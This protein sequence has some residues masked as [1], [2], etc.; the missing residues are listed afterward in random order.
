MFTFN[1]HVILASYS[2]GHWAANVSRSTC[3]Q[4][5]LHRSFANRNAPF[6]SSRKRLTLCD[7]NTA[8]KL[9]PPRFSCALSGVTSLHTPLGD[10]CAFTGVSAVKIVV[11]WRTIRSIRSTKGSSNAVARP[12]QSDMVERPKSTSSRD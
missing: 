7:R 6:T 4:A 2:A 11:P 5:L 9:R 12:D 3:R 8:M 10:C 1:F